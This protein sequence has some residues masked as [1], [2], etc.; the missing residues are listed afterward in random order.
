MFGGTRNR[1][2]PKLAKRRESS[3]G[4]H[5]N[6]RFSSVHSAP[7][8][9]NSGLYSGSM[10]G[11]SQPQEDLKELNKAISRIEQLIQ[12]PI[13]KHREKQKQKEE[14]QRQQQIAAL[15]QDDRKAPIEDDSDHG[16]EDEANE[17]RCTSPRATFVA[18]SRL[19]EEELVELIRRT[20]ELVVQGERRAAAVGKLDPQTFQ[21]ERPP[22]SA[23]LSLGETRQASSRRGF[24]RISSGRNSINSS[25]INSNSNNNSIVKNDSINSLEPKQS[26][27]E[28]ELMEEAESLK[29]KERQAHSALFDKFLER[30]VLSLF[31]NIATGVSFGSLLSTK[32]KAKRRNIPASTGSPPV[33]QTTTKG[34]LDTGESSAETSRAGTTMKEAK[35]NNAERPAASK[36]KHGVWIHN[37]RSSNTVFLPPLSVATQAVQSIAILLQ[38]VSQATSLYLLLSNNRVNDLIELPIDLYANAASAATMLTASPNNTNA[39]LQH[40]QQPTMDTYSAEISELAT[41]FVS[42]LKSLVMRINSETLQFFIR[43]ATEKRVHL[44]SEDDGHMLGQSDSAEGEGEIT[45]DTGDGDTATTITRHPPLSSSMAPTVAALLTPEEIEFPLYARALEFCSTDQ[46][47]FVRLTAMNI[48]LNTLRLAAVVVPSLDDDQAKDEDAVNKANCAPIEE[49]LQTQSATTAERRPDKLKSPDANVEF[50]NLPFRERVSIAHHICSP[51]RVQ[52]FVGHI[53]SK[54]VELFAA[55]EEAFQTLE[56]VVLEEETLLLESEESCDGDDKH[57]AAFNDVQTRRRKLSDQVSGIAADLQDEL[58]LLD[59]IMKMGLT[60]LNEQI[61]ETM[62]ASFVYPIL[63]EP[64]LVCVRRRGKL[65]MADEEEISLTVDAGHDAGSAH[66]PFLTEL[67]GSRSGA[68]SSNNN[69]VPAKT[70]LFGFYALFH[71]ISNAPLKHLLFAALLHPLSPDTSANSQAIT[72]Q[73]SVITVKGDDCDN[74]QV[75]YLRVDPEEDDDI[76]NEAALVDY[77]FGR[78]V[79]NSTHKV[80]SN[81]QE[82]KADRKTCIYVLAPAL[83]TLV[84]GDESGYDE[85]ESED[86]TRANQSKPNPYRQILLTC[87]SG[88]DHMGLQQVSSLALDGALWA[89]DR[90]ELEI[91]CGLLNSRS[92]TNRSSNNNIDVPQALSSES[93]GRLIE[94]VEALCLGIMSSTVCVNGKIMLKVLKIDFLFVVLFK[95]Y[96]FHTS[97]T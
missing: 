38:N 6:S 9:G 62:L 51:P 27:T 23:P 42:F 24:K 61:I 5:N 97:S 47:S 44:S 88:Q 66:H 46:D 64:L 25:S 63:L 12:Q 21:P 13:V 84:D 75:V 41:H 15:S 30:N 48:C 10:A 89:L 74:N 93:R 94:V 72:V 7:N 85:E 60:A 80:V 19:E 43:Y 17:E 81:G 26:M 91:M 3:H 37:K 11:T 67:L 29:E 69:P 79:K 82:N 56:E 76:D 20:A 78:S 36:T 39:L 54:L 52:R 73:P 71:A 49:L 55:L 86:N 77:D 35:Q 96:A 87:V 14:E 92:T 58:L 31:V 1:L 8:S 18:F 32:S 4:H 59:D 90:C 45:G 22:I 83:A 34:T 2:L 28:E 65:S 70:S 33:G 95:T 68:S 40:Q 53:F 50:V 57:D 16:N